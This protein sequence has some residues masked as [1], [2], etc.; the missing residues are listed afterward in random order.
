MPFVGEP[1]A[2]GKAGSA[3]SSSGL[4]SLHLIFAD[5]SDVGLDGSDVTT[6]EN[7]P[8]LNIAKLHRGTVV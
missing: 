5:G 8:L 1:S 7:P 2:A 4:R 6:L 3:L